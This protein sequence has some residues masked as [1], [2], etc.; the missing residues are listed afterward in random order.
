[1][2]AV[3]VV[4]LTVI[5][6]MGAYL[7]VGHAPASGAGPF[8]NP[9]VPAPTPTAEPDAQF[10]IVAGGDVLPHMPVLESAHTSAGYD[11]T[12]L[13]AG[14]DPWVSGA[15]LALCNMEIPVAPPGTAPSGYPVFGTVPDVVRDL[16]EQGWDGCST[17]TNHAVDRG[18]AGVDTTISTFDAQGLGHVGTA[19]NQA[20]DTP[21][22]YRLER[23]GRTF[24]I[25]QLSVTFGTNGMPVAHPWSVD[26]ID[27]D[28]IIARA[29]QARADGADMVLVSMHCCEEYVTA[30]TAQQVS[31]ATALAASGEVDLVIGHHAHVPQ[32]IELLPG[33]PDG[34][35]MWVAYGLGNYV[36]NQ[37]S[38]CCVPET[39]SGE[40]LVV[41]VTATGAD[42]AAGTEAG[43]P[44]VT[45][46]SYLPITVDRRGGHKVYALP[47]IT[48]GV[49]QLSSSEVAA[50]LA[51][52]ASAAG[53]Q[54]SIATAPPTPTGDPPVVVPRG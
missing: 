3:V 10:T 17:A 42:P 33:G 12:P 26:L 43:P 27:A 31:V 24:T 5:S 48:G 11:F 25:A 32:P 16:K 35:G 37:D 15:D 21:Q 40:L 23:A 46:V 1:M 6:G 19:S 9:F 41:Q 30:P 50:R 4:A 38:A 34:Q 49:G 13:L 47:E 20:G 8:R 2:L 22:L 36:S 53:P 28:T 54:V 14:L 45:S 39:S 52:V 51:R 29:T 18:Q 7:L 44:T